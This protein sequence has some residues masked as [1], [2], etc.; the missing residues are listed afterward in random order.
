LI[1]RIGLSNDAMKII[2][3]ENITTKLKRRS[4]LYNPFVFSM[5]NKVYEQHACYLQKRLINNS[6][7]W[8][9]RDIGIC[10]INYEVF[11]A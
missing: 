3:V 4:V 6:G 8:L 5:N 1:K 7:I 10:L 11:A 2:R 9:E